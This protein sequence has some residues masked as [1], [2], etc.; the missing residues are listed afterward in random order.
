MTTD[1]R[2]DPVSTGF[3]M[4]PYPLAEIEYVPVVVYVRM[5]LPAVSRSN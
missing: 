5:E 3:E 2:P 4:N 1:T